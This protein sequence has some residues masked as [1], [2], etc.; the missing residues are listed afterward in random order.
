MRTGLPL[1]TA[2]LQ[3]VANCSSRRVPGAHVAG[4]DAVLIERAR[5]IGILGQ[6]DVPVVVKIAD[7]RRVAARIAQP[8]DDFRHGRGRFRH[9]HRDAHQFRPGVGKFLALRHGPGDVRGIRVGHRL[10]DHRRAAAH[11]NVAD[12]DAIPSC[13]A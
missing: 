13:A 7:D 6:Q 1:S 12:L 8:R 2:T 9:V 4:I 3:M 5:A 11:L 10:D